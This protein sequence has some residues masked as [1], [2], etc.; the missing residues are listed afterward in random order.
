MGDYYDIYSMSSCA[1]II[2]QYS[3]IGQVDS[4]KMLG[5]CVYVAFVQSRLSLFEDIPDSFC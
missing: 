5:A 3:F 2:D 1:S 4:Q